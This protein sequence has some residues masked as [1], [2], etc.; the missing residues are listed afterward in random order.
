[1]GKCSKDRQA[2]RTDLVEAIA[3]E[4]DAWYQPGMP[5]PTAM[6][7]SEATPATEVMMGLVDIV[8]ARHGRFTVPG[9]R[10]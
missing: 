7:H 1:V 8:A 4:S 5:V 10:L 2:I 3:K 6:R 9:R